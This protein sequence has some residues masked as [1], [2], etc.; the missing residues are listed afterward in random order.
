MTSC[1]Q[2]LSE[3]EP[4]HFLYL[5]YEMFPSLNVYKSRS[6]IDKI[7]AVAGKHLRHHT[8]WR[9]GRGLTTALDSGLGGQGVKMVLTLRM[10]LLQ[11]RKVIIVYS[12]KHMKPI[13]TCSAQNVGFL[14]VEAGC[15]ASRLRCGHFPHVH[16]VQS[17]S[18]ANHSVAGV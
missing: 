4:F 5:S 11:L 18:G 17:G 8:T 14:N 6:T 9:C 1:L 15:I 10:I 12:E 7:A 3:F 13:I 2:E 16:S